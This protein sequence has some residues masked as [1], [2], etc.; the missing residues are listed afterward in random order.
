MNNNGEQIDAFTEV[1]I[2][3]LK[4]YLPT[5]ANLAGALWSTALCHWVSLEGA[6][7]KVLCLSL[8]TCR[9]GLSGSPV[10][11]STVQCNA[12]RAN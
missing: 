11:P 8:S 9:W 7:S 6:T 3:R 10:L 5:A 1:Q 2:K 4:T 12:R